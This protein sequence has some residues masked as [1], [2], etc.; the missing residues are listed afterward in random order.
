M[1]L[2][3]SQSRRADLKRYD[4]YSQ[5]NLSIA[6]FSGQQ[7][8]EIGKRPPATAIEDDIRRCSKPIRGPGCRQGSTKTKWRR[9]SRSGQSHEPAL[10]NDVIA[11]KSEDPRE[12][13]TVKA[14]LGSPSQLLAQLRSKNIPKLEPGPEETDL[15]RWDGAT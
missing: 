11:A 14:S 10:F 8:D 2:R 6:R 13:L 15:N 1:R 7:A 12:K 9:T 4:H 3:R 5:N